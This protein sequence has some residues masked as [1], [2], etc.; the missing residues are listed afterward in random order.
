M[1]RRAFITIVSGSIIASP[2][3]AHAQRGMRPP[4]IGILSPFQPSEPITAADTFRRALNEVGYA[5]SN[6]VQFEYRTYRYSDP[7]AAPASELVRSNV[8]L[9]IAA[10]VPAVRAAQRATTT[11]PIVM[12]YS[13]DPVRLGLVK[14]L[15]QPGG[16][17]TGLAPLTFD[18]APKRLELLKEALPKLS[19]VGVLWDPRN[20]AVREGLTQTEQAGRALGV[21]VEAFEVK[22]ASEFESVFAA[23]LRVRLDGLIVLPDVLT[24]DHRVGIAAFAIQHRLPSIWGPTRAVDAGGL[25]SY[26]INL[27]EHARDAARYIVKILKGVKP[28][29]LPVEQPTK[30]WLAVN[31]KTAKAIGLT[32]PQPLLLRADHVIE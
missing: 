28:S 5:E 21:R 23:I 22:D 6:A 14:S 3:T 16:N 29:E 27:Q 24:D 4:R 31:L 7:T 26:G 12:M 2:L 19:H 11:I 10:T 13:S 9:I 20:P 32:I 17:T 30:F 25:L 8:D 1:D 15:A 18:L